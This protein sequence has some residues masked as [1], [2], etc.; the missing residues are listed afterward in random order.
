M[1]RAVY[2]KKDIPLVK[3]F[4]AKGA[5]RAKKMV[6]FLFKE[7]ISKRKYMYCI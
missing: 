5:K 1:Y 2:P 4:G 3:I 7:S 6:L